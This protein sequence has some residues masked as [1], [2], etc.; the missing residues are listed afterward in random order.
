MSAN[1][2]DYLKGRFVLCFAPHL[3]RRPAEHPSPLVG[4]GLGGEGFV[5]IFC[6]LHQLLPANIAVY[7]AA[8]TT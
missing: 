7:L 2:G 1:H 8:I 5:T 6:N 3:V 4:E